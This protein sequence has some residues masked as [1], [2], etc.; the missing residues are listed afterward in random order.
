M[1][2]KVIT[3]KC[4]GCK[5]C[6]KSCPFN[7]IEIINKKAVIDFDKCTLCGAC[8]ESCKFDAI[9]LTKLSPTD[10]Q[11]PK[12]FDE[13]KD[14]WVFCEQKKGVVQS[15]AYE[16]LGKARELAD[17]LGVELCGVLLGEN[18]KEEAQKIIHRGANK[19]YL[20]DSPALKYYQ[21]EPYSKVLVQLIKEYKP[22]IVLCGATSIGRSLISRV[23]IGIHAGLTADCTGLDIDKKERLLLQTRPA[24]GGNIMATIICPNHRPQMST[25]RHKVMK[26]AAENKHHKGKII[27]KNYDSNIY[28]SR[29]RLLDI[30][31]EIEDTVNLTEAN[32]IVSGG[33]GI[34]SPEN[35]KLIE[36]LAKTLGGAVGASR[37]AVD[38]GWKTYS[39]QVGQTGK[40]VCPK[41]YIACGISGQIQHLVGMQ[42]S[43]II[44]AINKDPY[45]PIFSVATYGIVGDVFEVVPEL[46]RQFKEA[47]KR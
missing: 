4:T 37:A 17:T 45:A 6:V 5:L 41:I 22:E 44:V 12:K 38:S 21:D 43:E 34:Q 2:I 36:D 1:S 30:V 19:A 35:F 42:S 15:V 9:V 8:I 23:A 20:V 18:M 13:Y 39:H 11:F 47:L 27:E 24:F 14:V 29:T 46:T 10:I 25:V 16:L 7:A 32:V 28:F 31:E 26:E 33:R 3:E 40:T